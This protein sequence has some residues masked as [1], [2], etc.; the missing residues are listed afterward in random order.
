M[1]DQRRQLLHINPGAAGKQGMHQ[2]GTLVRFTI[3]GAEIRDLEIMEL[4][5][6]Q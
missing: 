2:V 1:N 5:R 4:P 6:R 3:E